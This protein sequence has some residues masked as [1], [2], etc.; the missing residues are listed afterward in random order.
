[1]LDMILFL[2]TKSVTRSLRIDPDMG[3]RSCGP[4]HHKI[5]TITIIIFIQKKRHHP[6]KANHE[7]NK[8]NHKTK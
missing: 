6:D 5:N 2:I 3:N 1:M 7:T 8:V 4:N